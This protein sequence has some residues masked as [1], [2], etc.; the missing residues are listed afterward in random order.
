MR[1]MH[2]K[3]KYGWIVAPLAALAACSPKSQLT[4]NETTQAAPP[5]PAAAAEAPVDVPAGEYT[6]DLAH[7]SVLFRVDHLGFSKYTARFKRSSARL[8]FDP[9]SLAA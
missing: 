9:T 8:Q 4:T 5:P 1:N 3:M 2:V 6:L 7:T